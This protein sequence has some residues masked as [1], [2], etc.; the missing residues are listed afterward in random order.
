MFIVGCAQE[1]MQTDGTC[2]QPVWLPYP[3][4]ILPP[5]DLADGSLVT[6]AIISVW[7]V[8]LKARLIFK[9]GRTGGYT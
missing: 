6:F 2:T 7:V 5:L 9:A 8:G 3:Q 1:N 4:Q